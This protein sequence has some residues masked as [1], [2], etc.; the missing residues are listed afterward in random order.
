MKTKTIKL[1]SVLGLVLT[2]SFMGGCSRNETLRPTVNETTE[3]PTGQA[4]K[5]QTTARE[6]FELSL[7]ERARRAGVSLAQAQAWEKSGVHIANNGSVYSEDCPVGGK[8]RVP[9]GVSIGC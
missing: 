5:T 2:A 3:E 1:S 4:I 9:G 6:Y 8:V 7:E